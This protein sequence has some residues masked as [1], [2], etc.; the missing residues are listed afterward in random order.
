MASLN[1]ARFDLVSIRL[2]VT[3]AQ[4]GS[5]T[6]AAAEA[7]LALAAASRRL[8][9]RQGVVRHVRLCAGTAAITQFL[10]PLLAEY[11]QAAPRGSGRAGR[12]GLAAGGG[13]GARAGAPTSASTWSAPMHRGLDVRDFRE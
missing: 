13:H 8:R 10:P 4:S 2:A 3:A 6:A 1:L 5:L 7:H 12:A 9:E 11:A